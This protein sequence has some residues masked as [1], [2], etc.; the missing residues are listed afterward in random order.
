M[1][2]VGCKKTEAHG[3]CLFALI[4]DLHGDLFA[5]TLGDGPHEDTDLLDDPALPTNDLA[6]IAVGDANLIYGA[7]RS[8][9][10]T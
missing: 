2:N 9:T 5:L 7:L 6:H 4:H 10:E 3:P 8:V 1:T